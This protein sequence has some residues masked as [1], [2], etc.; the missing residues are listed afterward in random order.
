MEDASIIELFW[1]RSEQAIAETAVKYGGYLLSIA[2]NILNSHEDAEECV[3][4]T[5]YKTW[6]A[7]PPNKPSFLK[8]WLGRITRN[9]SIDRYNRLHARKRG[10]GEIELI[11]EELENCIPASDTVERHWEDREIAELIDGFLKSQKRENRIFFV[12]RYWYGD[13]VEQMARSYG[14]SVSKVKSS[15]F[16]TRKALKALLE[17][18]GVFL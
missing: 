13:S 4:D 2:R 18:E 5:Y 1:N 6:E 12:R 16:R 14:A 10:A 15:L 9:L 8:C 11:F 7:I 3:S 17:K